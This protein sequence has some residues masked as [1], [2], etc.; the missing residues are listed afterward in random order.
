MKSLRSPLVL[1][2]LSGLALIAAAC[3]SSVEGGGNGGGGATPGDLCP[4][5]E[6]AHISVGVEV[7][8]ES[9]GSDVNTTLQ[10]TISA[11]T[12]ES[13]TFQPDGQSTT[14]VLRLPA[15]LT[16]PSWAGQTASLRYGIDMP[17]WV[18]S[19]FVLRDATGHLLLAGVDGTAQW[20][21][22]PMFNAADLKLSL[23]G[24]CDAVDDSCQTKIDHVVVVQG[25]GTSLSLVG[26]HSG[27]VTLGGSS[28]QVRLGSAWDGSGPVHCS[29]V[30]DSWLN[31]VI[32]PSP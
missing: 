9:F 17:W 10:G 18:E 1:A 31:F 3:G 32:A 13:L 22:D 24:D 5:T 2:A 4:A 8:P 27:K 15:D 26:G 12:A 25:G 20:L 29:D 21:S 28:Y 14:I 23:G 6:D 30:P 16:L 7:P 19:S 11:Q